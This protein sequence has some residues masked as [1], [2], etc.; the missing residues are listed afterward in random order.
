MEGLI[1]DN[2]A[3]SKGVPRADAVASAT[4][5]RGSRLRAFRG[6]GQLAAG[7]A[8]SL[9]PRRTAGRSRARGQSLVEFALILPILLL[10]ALIAVDFGRVY[11]G[12]IN[13]Q[14]EARIAA[15]FAAN[16][17][18]AD[19]NDAT[20]LAPVQEPDRERRV[21]DELSARARSA[22]ETEFHGR[23]RQ[24]QVDRHWRPGDGQPDL[25]VQGRDTG[26][27]VRHRQHCQCQRELGLSREERDRRDQLGRRRW[28]RLSPAHGRHQR[29]TWH[30]WVGAS[31]G[32]V[33]GFV[34]G[35]FSYRLA[36]GVH[37]AGGCDRNQ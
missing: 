11:L 5:N 13:L 1:L 17:P 21:G 15:D 20:F 19:W 4:R 6:Y 18:L 32:H 14:N 12:W 25:S 22:R 2:P 8:R 7:R 36:L 27:L 35:R 31:D 23:R 30:H 3:T 24:R 9:A 34:G 28:R 10:L 16:N 26:H 29:D 33:P 37:R